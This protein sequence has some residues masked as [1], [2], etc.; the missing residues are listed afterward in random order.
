MGFIDKEFKDLD[1]E[2]ICQVFDY[3]DNLYLMEIDYDLFFKYLF[4]K[5]KCE[6]LLF[7][8]EFLILSGKIELYLEKMK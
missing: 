7:S 4:M 2:L 3:L 1:E 6:K 8:G 5:V